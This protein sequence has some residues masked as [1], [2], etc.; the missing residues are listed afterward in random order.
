MKAIANTFFKQYALYGGVLFIQVI[1]LRYV[2]EW[3]TYPNY[4]YVTISIIFH[5][6]CYRT[7]HPL[8]LA[9][10]INY[11]HRTT[12]YTSLHGWLFAVAVVVISFVN[13]II[14]HH[15]TLGCFK[16]GMR[17]R[18][19]CCSLLYRKVRIQIVKI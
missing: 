8:A 19:A 5:M 11:F 2:F 10:L 15:V 13:C 16:I 9:E 12:A 6:C 3:N 14:M 18:I 4:S 7:I 17:C 1:I